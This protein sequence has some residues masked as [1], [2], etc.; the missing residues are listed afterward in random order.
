MT[1]RRRAIDRLRRERVLADRVQALQIL[2]DLDQQAEPDARGRRAPSRDDR[3]RLIFTLLPPRARDRGARRPDAA[4]ARRPDDAPRSRAR[5]SSP[6]RRWP[7]ASSAPSARSRPPR[8]PYRVP[9][10]RRS[11]PTASPACSPSSTSSSTR[12]TPRASDDRLVRARAVRR[13]DPPRPAARRGSCPTTPRP[14][15]CSRSCSCTTRA[16]PRAPTPTARC[17][18][19][20]DQDRSRW[21]A[22]PDRGGHAHASTARCAC[23]GPGPTS[24]RPRS[25][26][27]T[28]TA[29]T[30]DETDWPQIAALYGRLVAPHA[31][32]RSCRSTARSRSAWR[33]GP[34]A[35]LGVLDALQGDPRLAGYQ[36]FHA[37]RAD[38]LAPRGRR[39]AAAAAYGRRDRAQ[40][41][42]RR[43]R[44][45]S[46]AAAS[47]LAAG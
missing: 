1:A 7:S 46:S 43:A 26:R 29:P 42:R 2:V 47:A 35:G 19:L 28:P 37:A 15:A 32:R 31:A 34:R 38:L 9:R 41:E 6:R 25:P 17:V 10:R 44:T 13:G 39:A 20:A 36:P 33:D 27:C 8:I 18:A 24:C 3:L 40:H 21:D 5:S 45:S 11:C 4:H 12:A 23:A 22:A 16:A 14:P 30:A